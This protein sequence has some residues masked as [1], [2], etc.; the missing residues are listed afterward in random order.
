MTITGKKIW[1]TS[2]KERI[3]TAGRNT[4]Y[5][6]QQKELRAAKDGVA[7]YQAG[8][9]HVDS[10]HFVQGSIDESVGDLDFPGDIIILRNVKGGR[11]VKAGGNIEVNGDVGDAVLIAESD[12]SIKGDFKGDGQGRLQAGGNIYLRTIEN[13]A[14]EAKQSIRISRECVNAQL[15]A[16]ESIFLTFNEVG[17][18][19]GHLQAGW[20]VTAEILGDRKKTLTLVEV[21]STEGFGPELRKIENEITEVEE[22]LRALGTEIKSLN[23]LKE[24]DIGR[25]HDIAAKLRNALKDHHKGRQQ[26]SQLNANLEQARKRQTALGKRGT[27]DVKTRTFPGVV[28]QVGDSK[29]ELKEPKG[30]VEFRKLGDKIEAIKPL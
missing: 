12:I 26:L 20:G 25:K 5:A 10:A 1:A 18:S 21:K 8:A 4:Y 9:I 30:E 19:G 27:V 17:A 22:K 2:E 11:T 28:I 3:I 29:L 24:S 6:D 13:Q 14:A 7:S 15:N 23:N 16:G